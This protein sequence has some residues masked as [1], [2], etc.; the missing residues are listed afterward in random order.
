MRAF[1]GGAEIRITKDDLIKMLTHTM[2][3]RVFGF[4]MNK[5][6]VTDISLYPDNKYVLRMTVAPD[7]L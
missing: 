2:E 3:D 6:V 4:M 5:H 1:N 7:E